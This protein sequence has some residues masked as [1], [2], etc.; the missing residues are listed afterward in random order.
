MLVTALAAWDGDGGGVVCR[1]ASSGLLA[2]PHIDY[3]GHLSAGLYGPL[4][5]PAVAAHPEEPCSPG[6][7]VTVEP[8]NGPDC[9]SL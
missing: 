6:F 8:P 9:C 1:E 7:S 4:K 3:Q 2:P 5:N